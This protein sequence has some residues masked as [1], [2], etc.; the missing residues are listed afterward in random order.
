MR[1]TFGRE[2]SRAEP[3]GL[4]SNRGPLVAGPLPATAAGG[5]Q[6]EI[7]RRQWIASNRLAHNGPNGP[8]RPK[9]FDC[10]RLGAEKWRLLEVGRAGNKCPAAALTNSTQTWRDKWLG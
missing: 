6:I 7:G 1:A 4:E 2:P 8:L 5:G 10:V 3:T 9:L